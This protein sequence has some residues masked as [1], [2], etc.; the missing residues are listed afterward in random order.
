MQHLLDFVHEHT[1]EEQLYFVVDVA[2]GELELTWQ[3]RVTPEHWQLRPRYCEGP[4][5]LV[6]RAQLLHTL[7]ARSVDMSR[8]ERELQSLIATQIAFADMVLSD[9][10]ALLGADAV[11][12]AVL[13]HQSFM[14][15][16]HA[17]VERVRQPA[18]PPSPP[19]VVLPGG[20]ARSEL[21]SGH[22]TVV[23]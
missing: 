19:L 23:P 4:A 8:V 18:T 2:T 11:E 5:E 3:R 16:L 14:G 1:L 12:R 17:A 13:G 22:L 21:R 15:Q 9:A 6:Q 7:A 10:N 20:G